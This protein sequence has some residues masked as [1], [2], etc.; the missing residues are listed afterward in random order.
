MDCLFSSGFCHG[1]PW[2][3]LSLP[4]EPLFNLFSVLPA[5]P[6]LPPDQAQTSQALAILKPKIHPVEPA[7]ALPSFPSWPQATFLA[8]S[9]LSSS[10]A[11]SSTWVSKS[12]RTR[13]SWPRCRPWG[14]WA[15]SVW[16]EPQTVLPHPR[17]CVLRLSR[18]LT[19]AT[20]VSQNSWV[21]PPRVSEPCGGA[22]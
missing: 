11:P 2:R 13:R 5:Q 17:S 1:E 19:P 9:V 16:P 8:H 18:S 10:T 12:L 22:D 4:T 15:N 14:P 3:R 7:R 20:G 21:L 6:C